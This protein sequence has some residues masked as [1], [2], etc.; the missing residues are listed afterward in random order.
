MFKIAICTP[1]CP[2]ASIVFCTGLSTL[3]KTCINRVSIPSLA[4]R[5]ESSSRRRTFR[6]Y[7]IPLNVIHDQ[8]T[9]NGIVSYFRQIRN[10]HLYGDRYYDDPPPFFGV[11]LLSIYVVTIAVTQLEVEV[12]TKFCRTYWCDRASLVPFLS[13]CFVNE[14]I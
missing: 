3:K 10:G 14:M 4:S 13:A 1:L 11:I 6:I 8:G 7:G 9:V 12:K 5:L 2:I